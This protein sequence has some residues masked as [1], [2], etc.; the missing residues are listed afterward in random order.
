MKNLLERFNKWVMTRRLRKQKERAIFEIE[1][2]LAYLEKFKGSVIKYDE[3][4]ARKRMAELKAKGEQRTP[5]EE[6]ELEQVL[7]VIAESKAVKN[8]YSKS[9]ALLNDIRNYVSCLN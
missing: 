4:K 5:I 7:N 3:G 2:D 1:M 6:T 9:Q 8:E